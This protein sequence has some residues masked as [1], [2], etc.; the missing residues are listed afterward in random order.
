MLRYLAANPDCLCG[1]VVQ[2]AGLAQST[3]SS[4]LA[5]LRQAGL[6]C[7]TEDGPATCLCVNMENLRSLSVNVA[8]LVGQLTASACGDDG[9]CC[10]DA[11][12]CCTNDNVRQASVPGDILS[13]TERVPLS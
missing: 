4:H 3:V 11:A 12:S 9:D 10:A 2:F 1:E 13:L 5:V 7:G 8:D 6:V